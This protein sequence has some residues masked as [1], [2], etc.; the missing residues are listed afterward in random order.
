MKG[1]TVSQATAAGHCSNSTPSGT[2]SEETEI[3]GDTKVHR[4]FHLVL[5]DG[6]RTLA[7]YDRYPEYYEG[8]RAQNQLDDEHFKSQVRLHAIA[9]AI[10]CKAARLQRLDLLPRKDLLEL[11]RE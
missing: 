3:S 4:Y 8:G 6:I 5:S 10:D 2:P 1:C 9:A 7:Y 11:A